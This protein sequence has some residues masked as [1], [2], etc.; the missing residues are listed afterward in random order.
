M[1]RFHGIALP[2]GGSWRPCVGEAG[3]GGSL[4][5]DVGIARGD[6]ERGIG[7]IGTCIVEVTFL[8]QLA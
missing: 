8:D 5:W 2:G 7:C 3:D 6:G 4:T 1:K